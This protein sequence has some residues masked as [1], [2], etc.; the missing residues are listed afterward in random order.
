MRAAGLADDAVEHGDFTEAGGERAAAALLADH[1]DLDGIVVASDLMAAG[2]LKVLAATGRRVP[3]D[4]AVVGYDDLGVAERTT[5]AL[6]TV[7]NPSRRWP[8]AP[9]GCSSSR[10]TAHGS[11]RPMRRDHP[12]AAGPPRQRLTRR[13]HSQRFAGTSTRPLRL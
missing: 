11:G 1:P 10:S 4:V 5:P 2:A 12:A 8:S 7:R 13:S 6:T 9:P 3:D